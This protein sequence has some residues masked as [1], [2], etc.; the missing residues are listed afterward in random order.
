[1]YYITKKKLRKLSQENTYFK[2]IYL[3]LN[4]IKTTGIAFINDEIFAQIKYKENTGKTLNLENPQSFNEKLWWLKINYRIPLMTICSDKVLVRD[5]LSQIGLDLLLNDIQGVYD[6]FDEIPFNELQGK[7]FIKCNHVSGINTIYDSKN[8]SEFDFKKTNDL[9]SQALK[10]NYYYQ[11]RE[12]NYKNIKPKII[13]EK[14]IESQSALLDY[15]FLC[16]HGKVKLIFVDINTASQSGEHNPCAQRNVY[17][18]NFVLQDFSVG[19]KGFDP[20][21]VEKPKELNLMIEYAEKIST[22][23]IFCRVDLYNN[24]G[25]IKFGEVT[26]YP[27]GATQQFSSE[28]KDLEVGSWI[29]LNKT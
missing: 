29:D 17:D 10:M 16:F 12:W 1:M 14:F 8:K 21:L 18:K 19:R 15:R 24:Q 11:S 2:S 22:P 25:E 26:F 6:K 28:E 7:F 27:G 4:K 20:D 13:V 23:F 3:K 9:F 5:Y